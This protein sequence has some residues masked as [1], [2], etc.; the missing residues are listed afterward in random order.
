MIHLDL[1]YPPTVNTYWR[2]NGVR[3]F[4]AKRG[5]LFRSQVAEIV[6]EAQQGSI[7]GRLSVFVALYPPDKRKRDIDNV[8]KALLDALSHA[9]AYED[10]SQIDRLEVM[11]HQ[12]I[13]GGKCS[14]VIVRVE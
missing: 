12:V 4:I 9:G 3:R 2:A 7:D 8:L 14:V 10:D 6:S 11:R 5:V 13:K 1:P